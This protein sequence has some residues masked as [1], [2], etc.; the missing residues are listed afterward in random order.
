M[1][2]LLQLAPKN[3]RTKP[4]IESQRLR[5]A[6]PLPALEGLQCLA[7]ASGGPER[8]ASVS[9]GCEN[10]GRH[11]PIKHACGQKETPLPRGFSLVVLDARSLFRL[12]SDAVRVWPG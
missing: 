12:Y 6:Y 3:P 11:K 5:P 10:H 1:N 9:G 4:I 8:E 7:C 2:F